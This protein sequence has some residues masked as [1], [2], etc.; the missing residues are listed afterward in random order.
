MRYL[1]ISVLIFTANIAAIARQLDSSCCRLEVTTSPSNPT[2]L[3]VKIVNLGYPTLTVTQLKADEDLRVQI[4]TWD[5]REPPLT[6]Y[7]RRRRQEERS[8]NLRIVEVK[9]G[10]SLIESRDLREV[11]NLPRGTYTVSVA[12]E[13]IVNNKKIEL[14]AKIKIAAP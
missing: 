9:T 10:E 11:Y 14:Q 8:G 4:V 1:A 3:L 6:E 12:R 5:G 2:E 13:V 7:G